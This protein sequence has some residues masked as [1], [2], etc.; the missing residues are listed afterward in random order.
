LDWRVSSYDAIPPSTVLGAMF[1]GVLAGELGTVKEFLAH[2][3]WAA[4]SAKRSQG[5][6]AIEQPNWERPR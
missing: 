5:S 3:Q 6:R 2:G 4:K 1:D